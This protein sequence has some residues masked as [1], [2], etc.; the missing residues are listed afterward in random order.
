MDVLFPMAHSVYE[1]PSQAIC[2]R[3]VTEYALYALLSDVLGATDP[4]AQAQRLTEELWRKR[5]LVQLEQIGL[6]NLRN[7][8][9]IAPSTYQSYGLC[10]RS[11]LSGN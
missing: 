8:Y 4:A 3:W 9:H 6:C 5:C 10:A 2:G 11:W 7:V 1:A